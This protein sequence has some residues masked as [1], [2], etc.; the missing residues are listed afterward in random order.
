LSA[1]RKSLLFPLLPAWRD[2]KFMGKPANIGEDR[3]ITN[4]ILK[5]GYDVVF[6]KNAVA[7]TNVPTDY[8]GLCKMFIRWARSNFRENFTMLKFAFRKFNFN[9]IGMQINLI[10][11]IIYMFTPMCFIFTSI[12]CIA[13]DALAFFYS[14]ITVITLWSTIPAFFYACRYSKNESLWSY[15][16]GIFNFLALSWIAP[17]ALLTIHKSGWLTRK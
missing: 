15:V 2:E 11:Q 10:M 4:L 9:W 13:V 7:F 8:T 14:V 1:Y 16:Y 5:N 12:Y 3:G 6:Q 17:Y